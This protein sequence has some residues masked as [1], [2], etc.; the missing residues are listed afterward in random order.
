M[1]LLL[2]YSKVT[3]PSMMSIMIFL[4]L[5]EVICII[6]VWFSGDSSTICPGGKNIRKLRINHDFPLNN[7]VT[8]SNT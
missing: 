6:F 7:D 4:P 5:E 3:A 2:Y 1:C 8:R